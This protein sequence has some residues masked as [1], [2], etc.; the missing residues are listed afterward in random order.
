MSNEIVDSSLTSVERF[1]SRLP[2]GTSPI[3]RTLLFGSLGAGIA[4]AVRPSMS[5]HA[6]GRPR[7]WILL[8]RQNPEATLFPWWAYIVVPGAIAGIFI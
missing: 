8:D 3:G 5:F 6:D 1:M 2:L 4:Y 7:E